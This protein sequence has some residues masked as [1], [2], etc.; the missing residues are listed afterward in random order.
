[1]TKKILLM[2][3]DN[4]T[5]EAAVK[6]LLKTQSSLFY[7]ISNL[8]ENA[9]SIEGLAQKAADL[10]ADVWEF[11]GAVSAVI[12]IAGQSFKNTDFSESEWFIE[13]SSELSNGESLYLRIYS[14]EKRSFIEEE[15]ELLTVVAHNLSAKAERIYA[16]IKLQEEQDLL[17][18]A[19]KLAHIG[20][21]EYDMIND[22]LYWSEVT[23]EVHGFGKDYEPDVESTIELFKEGFHRDTFAKAAEDAIEKEIPFDLELKII[24]GKGD[25]RWIRATGEPEYKNGECIR[26][27]GISQNV[28]ERRKAEEE[29]ALN[30]RRFRAMVRHGMDLIAILDE[31]ANY[32]FASPTSMKVLGFPPEYF[33][34][35][36][37]FDFIHRDDKERIQ[38]QFSELAPQQST[39]LAPFRFLDGDDQWRWLEATITN[40][41][42][43]PAVQG[44]VSNSRDVTE[45]QIKQEQIIDSLKEKETLLA[46]VHHR[47]KNNLSVL[48]GLLQ[49]QAADEENEEVLARLFDSVA[50][51]HTMASIH[52]QLYQ[53][54][55]FSSIELGERIKLLVL[56]IQKSFQSKTKVEID[57]QCEPV[58]L[59]VS[60]ALPCSLVVNEVITNIFKHAFKGKDKGKIKIELSRT[61]VSD[62][63]RLAISDNGSGLPE[64]F[65][66]EESN[67]LGLR[68]IDMLSEQMKSEYYFEN[69]KEGTAFTL[70]FKTM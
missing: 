21:W 7:E 48:M 16:R 54:S 55:N 8:N 35:K 12:R 58:E 13:T 24:S 38:K 59:E 1:M 44:Y 47:V 61:D 26:F 20:T 32:K 67:S 6:K 22:K 60:R 65:N 43:D 49:L 18:K 50:R 34:E 42:N 23:K 27:Y 45:R 68:L 9:H 15:K 51:I 31:E 14:E 41:M 53:T 36:N 39:Q 25:E 52:E 46:E 29:V 19:Y 69:L 17:D 40:M 57:F 63:M 62:F 2:N 64:N 30:D 11:Q 28:T 70:L 5:S 4:I 3:V 10:I 37:A 33:L 66:P 56:D